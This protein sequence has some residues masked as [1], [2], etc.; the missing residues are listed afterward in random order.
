[1]SNMSLVDFLIQH[2]FTKSLRNH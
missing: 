2:S 1:M